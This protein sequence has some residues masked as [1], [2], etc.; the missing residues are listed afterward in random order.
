MRLSG[1]LRSSFF[2]CALM[3][4]AWPI[5]FLSETHAQSSLPPVTVDAPDVRRPVSAARQAATTRRGATVRRARSPASAAAARPIEQGPGSQGQRDADGSIGVVA[6]QSSAGTKTNTPLIETPQSISVITRTQLESQA[7]RN[8][9]QALNYTS[10]VFGEPRGQVNGYFEFPYIRGFSPAGFLYLN[11]LQL[12]GASAGLQIEP[13]GL[14]RI[15][16]VKGPSSILYGSGPPSGIV[17]LV[18]KMPTAKQFGEIQLSGGDFDRKQVAFDIG[19]PADPQGQFLYRLTGLVR[20]AQ[21]QVDFTRDDRY[22]I[23]PAVTWRPNENTS[24]TVLAQA[25][26][27]NSGFFNFL[28]AQGTFLPNVNGRI[29]TSLYGGDPNFNRSTIES[30]AVGYQF[31]H[32]FSDVVTVRQN[33]RHA[34]LDVNADNIFTGAFLPNQQR[35]VTR[36]AFSNRDRYDADTLD[37]QV[38]L[39]F[40]TFDLRHTVL[41]GY[42]FQNSVQDKKTGT[43]VAPS[44]DL[45]NPT[46]YVPITAPAFTVNTTQ[47]FQQNGVYLQDQIKFGRFVT[48]LGIRNDRANT[49][50]LNNFTNKTASQ[51]DEATTKRA[52]LLYLF[53]SGVAPYGSYSE[54]FQP[55]PGTD[56]FGAAFKPTTGKQWEAGVKYQP[57]FF[58]GLFTAA[59][60][61][62]TRQNVTTPDTAPG[63]Q[64]RSVQLGEVVS[65]GLEL[66]S[67]VSLTNELDILAAYTYLDAKVTKSTNLL[68]DLGKRPV[69]IPTN[70]AS[71]WADYTFRS[72]ALNG[73]GVAGGVRYTGSTA[74][75]ADNSIEVPSYTLYDAAIHYELA[76]LDPRLKGFKLAVNATNLF[77]R[78]YTASCLS[79]TNNQCFY[80]L[81]RTV[82]GSLT[83]R[84]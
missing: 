19:G 72:G 10:G 76:Y 39:N 11:G 16:V 49:D 48:Q 51:T 33:Y 73:F 80:G 31:E 18:S 26:K 68:G 70:A 13:Y 12:L 71:L 1:Y 77:D 22:F 2:S 21:T 65:R 66:E 63:H 75:N 58:N 17:N 46:Y 67:R 38:Q 64:G 82:L 60:F 55:Q 74:A 57:T 24:F 9:S 37:N 83:Y 54:S 69:G 61:E 84:W 79:T 27:A 6:T 7:V 35:I 56:F 40:N 32:R 29:S 5:S 28:P 43:G 45:F 50:T 44:L 78:V 81:R 8:V 30:A 62:I 36:T 41:A 25:Q 15:E 3:S 20:D 34:W 14:Q 53:D 4:V 59:V 42:D 47:D 23:A 52:G